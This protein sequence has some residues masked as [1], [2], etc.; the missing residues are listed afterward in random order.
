MRLPL[1]LLTLSS[2]ASCAGPGFRVE[3]LYAEREL[4]DLRLYTSEPL[5]TQKLQDVKTKRGAVRVAVGNPDDS[6][7]GYFQVIG[8]ELDATTGAGGASFE[9]GGFG[10]G[11]IGRQNLGSD[12]NE[13]HLILPYR[14]GLDY[15]EGNAEGLATP[16]STL[17][18]YEAYIF[19]A[20]AGLGLTYA[21]FDLVLG[22]ALSRFDGQVKIASAGGTH[23]DGL[24]GT[25]TG[26]W[27][28]AAYKTPELPFRVEA[29]LGFGDLA[30]TSFTVGLVY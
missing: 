21:G 8:E 2:L 12:T 25:N 30:E 13:L 27:A 29:R 26:P 16:T 3:A 9:G 1:A 18:D 4:D 15:I 17:G 14:A 10:V 22:Y 20:E 23:P 11:V 6:A 24:R 7:L 28:A 5:A 19:E